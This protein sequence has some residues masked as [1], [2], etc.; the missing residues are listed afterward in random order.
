M[1]QVFLLWKWKIKLPQNNSPWARSH[2]LTHDL[3]ANQ[4]LKFSVSHKNK[5]NYSTAINEY[6]QRQW[7]DKDIG[8]LSEWNPFVWA[9][10]CHLQKITLSDG[11][12]QE[13]K[14]I[15]FIR[16]DINAQTHLIFLENLKRHLVLMYQNPQIFF[17]CVIKP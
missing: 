16:W 6:L 17:V 12:N 11:F 7:Y 2:N 3:K 8:I 4:K 9:S 15:K 14:I 1:Q 13:K 10:V 5:R